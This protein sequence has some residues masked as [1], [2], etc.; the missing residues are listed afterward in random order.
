MGT[1]ANHVKLR[2]SF[3]NL[4]WTLR[5]LEIACWLSR[6]VKTGELSPPKSLRVKTVETD[7]G[8]MLI[9]HPWKNRFRDLFTS[10]ELFGDQ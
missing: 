4:L 10:E 8:L 7:K 3:N 5:R 1:Y 6:N 9:L 2:K